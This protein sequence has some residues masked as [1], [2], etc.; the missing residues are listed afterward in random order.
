MY[1]YLILLEKLF[2]HLGATLRAFLEMNTNG[3]CMMGQA[4]W[5][6]LVCCGR[7]GDLGGTSVLRWTW[8]EHPKGNQIGVRS[9][10]FCGEI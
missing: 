9:G 8:I 10:A 1:G 6:I 2:E 4:T 7:V 5:L 3:Q